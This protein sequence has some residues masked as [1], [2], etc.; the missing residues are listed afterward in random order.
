MTEPLL[1]AT[2]ITLCVLSTT[3]LI[4]KLFKRIKTSKCMGVNLEFSDNKDS[5]GVDLP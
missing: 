1:T 5:D 4:L 3:K 2:L